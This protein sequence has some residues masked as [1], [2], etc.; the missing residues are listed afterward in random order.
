MTDRTINLSPWREI[1]TI[2]KIQH[3][4]MIDVAT[5]IIGYNDYYFYIQ[6]DIEKIID[7]SC[8]PNYIKED[9]VNYNKKDLTINIVEE[10]IRKYVDLRDSEVYLEVTN[11]TYDDVISEL[12]SI[13]RDLIIKKIII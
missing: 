3:H 7:V 5:V 2:K 6:E 12:Q 4:T 10:H 13:K 11:Q 8:M 1:S 9:W